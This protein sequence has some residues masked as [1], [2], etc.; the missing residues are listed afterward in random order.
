MSADYA[1]KLDFLPST[2]TTQKKGANKKT[3]VVKAPEKLSYDKTPEELAESVA[4]DV[5]RQLAPKRPEPK[6]ILPLET[7][8]KVVRNLSTGPPPLPDLPDDYIRCIQKTY[9]QQRQEEEAA[10]KL[11]R[12]QERTA[13]SGKQVAQLGEQANQSIPPLK[14][15]PDK[16]VHHDTG[17]IGDSGYPIEYQYAWTYVNGKS[18]V[19]PEA[20]QFLT[21]QLRQ[22]HQ[23]YMK[24]AKAGHDHL[25]VAY[26]KEHYFRDDA[27]YVQF[28][29]IFQ[30]FNQDALDKALV[31]CYCL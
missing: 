21:T 11:K 14:V 23:W 27:I 30:L 22:L 1:R 24:A 29:E 13:K 10:Y 9:S 4:A 19:R 7:V 3:N 20:V 15:M 28:S 5:K 12:E 25:W 2:S 16:E 18:L 6:K 8:L 31:S 17:R 26:R